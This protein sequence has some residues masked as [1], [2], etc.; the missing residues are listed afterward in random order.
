MTRSKNLILVAISL[1][2]MAQILLT[3]CI[4]Q[5]K[6]GDGDLL[7]LLTM[8]AACVFCLLFI[9]RSWRYSTTQF[10]FLMALFG[11]F[12]LVLPSAPA[13]IQGVMFFT[14]S[15]FAYALRLYISEKR[16]AYRKMQII[17]RAAVSV[18]AIGLT[19]LILKDKCDS[20][21]LISIFYYV[22][23]LLNF[24]FACTQFRDQFLLAIGFLLF[25]FSDTVLGLSFLDPYLEL[26]EGSVLD[27]IIHSGFDFIWAF[28]IPA[29]IFLVFS[30]LPKHWRNISKMKEE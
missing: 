11:D 28:Y 2:L 12:F 23:L 16:S 19:V 7:R 9:D 20:V 26:A 4:F 15:H 3:V 18:F 13:Q 21:S 17:V 14:L 22:N 29:Q 30:L 6:A 1:F 10:A 5:T 24:G 8:M 25:I 27:F